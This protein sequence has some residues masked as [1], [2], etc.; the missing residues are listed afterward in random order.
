V[1]A[2]T[3][4]AAPAS[5]T[6]GGTTS[7]RSLRAWGAIAFVLFLLTS[8]VGGSLGLESSYLLIT[9]ASHIG[10]ALVTLGVT[11]YVASTMRRT[12]PGS[13]RAPSGLAAFAALGGT[14]A[15]TAYLLWGQSN[16]A[17]YAMEAF[18]VLGILASLVM[19][20]IGRPA[21]ALPPDRIGDG[22]PASR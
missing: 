8:A 18:A 5:S 16:F 9:L 13:S 3:P 4:P 20:V 21:G 6:V 22:A 15:G 2:A 7:S 17:L 12:Y 14:L 10:L 1:T 11:G 19:I